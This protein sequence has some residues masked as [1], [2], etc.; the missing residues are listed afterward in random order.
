MRNS[1]V[2]EV[3]GWLG[4]LGK[5]GMLVEQEGCNSHLAADACPW[6]V[7]VALRGSS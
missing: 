7:P 6:A 1:R 3:D 5:G 4:S 2:F